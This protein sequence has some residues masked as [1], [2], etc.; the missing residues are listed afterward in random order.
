MLCIV[1]ANVFFSA[2]FI[3][4]ITGW[5]GLL[6]LMKILKCNKTHSETLNHLHTFF[7]F[8][9]NEMACGR[10]MPWED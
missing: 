8:V 5:F 3:I 10:E 9:A 6:V 2:L 4:S 1:S 7:F